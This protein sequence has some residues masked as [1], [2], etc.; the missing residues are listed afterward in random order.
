MTIGNAVPPSDVPSRDARLAALLMSVVGGSVVGARSFE[1][2]GARVFVGPER[3]F[4]V[5]RDVRYA[6]MDFSTLEKRHQAL[7]R[8][9]EINRPNA[10]EIYLGL[11]PVTET[12]DG[13]LALGGGGRIVEWALEMRAFRQQDLL[14][15]IAAERPLG[16]ELAIATADAIFEMHRSAMPA[17]GV[18]GG[19]ASV[20]TELAEA[21]AAA[22]RLIDPASREV[23]FRD[24]SAELARV[25]PLL[26]LR[27]R[28][29]CVRRCHGDLHLAN[30]VLWNGRPVPFD[31]L[32]FD[33]GLATIDVLYDLAFLLMDLDRRD[34]RADAH[35]ILDRYLW[36]SRAASDLDALAALPLFLALRAGI[37]AMVAT[38]K[39][40]LSVTP[41]ATAS[42]AVAYF[43]RA[44]GYLAPDPP[45]LVAIGGLS[46]TGKS[47]LGAALA[48][49]L[50]RAPGA[51]HLRSDLERK[52]L[53]GTDPLERLPPA[54][55]TPAAT[56]AVYERLLERAR[57]VLDAGHSCIVDAVYAQPEERAAVEALARNH[58]ARHAFIWLEAPAEVMKARVAGR[59]GDASD[60][61]P[62]VVEQQ[63]A[64]GTGAIDW[65]RIEAGASAIATRERVRAELGI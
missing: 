55:Y 44:Q 40:A 38:Q 9:L 48:P 60:A 47:T 26:D 21:L 32:E 43:H 54:A 36:R 53:A 65:T 41:G 1:T 39:A 4:K 52:A 46:G 25:A 61:T 37:R 15:E 7:R 2:H 62:A 45:M 8:E 5:K 14:A 57:R 23:W 56:R 10:P 28:A 30:I 51:I 29:G 18:E 63:L 17:P 42:E 13:T 6:Y 27:R 31:A 58:A 59:Q 12:D 64:R 22:P 11:V 24:L 19:L 3:A 33:E 16:P 35:T 50:G 20:I 49:T 34:R